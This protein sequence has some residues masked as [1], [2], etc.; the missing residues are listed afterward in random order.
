[1]TAAILRQSGGSIILAIP[2]AI[3]EAMGVTARSQV[4][5][6]LE[7]RVLTVRP[8]YRIE[9]LVAAYAPDNAHPL[10]FGGDEIGAERVE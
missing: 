4:S 3:A 1:M 5:L 8:G 2:K 7:G 9:D 6:S 10:A